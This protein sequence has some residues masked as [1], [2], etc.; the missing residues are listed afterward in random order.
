VVSVPRG[1]DEKGDVAAVDLCFGAEARAD[2]CPRLSG[3]VTDEIS[4]VLPVS[5]K[6]GF[7]QSGEVSA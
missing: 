4:E 1:A 3:D 2:G 6:P 5:V 7:C